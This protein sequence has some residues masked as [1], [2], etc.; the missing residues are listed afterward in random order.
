MGVAIEEVKETIELKPIARLFL[1]PDFIAGLINLRGDVVAVLD[2]GRMLGM[3]R[4][5][6]TPQSRI[7]ILRGRAPGKPPVAG[8]LVDRLSDVRELAREAIRPPPA[9][10]GGEGSAFVAGVARVADEPTERPLLVL[11]LQRILDAEPLRAF[12]RQRA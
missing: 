1:M 9:N 4:R 7:V 12:R 11:D 5:V 8:L 2:L 3:G 10:V 6:P